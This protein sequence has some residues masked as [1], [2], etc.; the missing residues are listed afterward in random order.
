MEKNRSF[1]NQFVI[2]RLQNIIQMNY[3]KNIKSIFAQSAIAIVFSV[4]FFAMPNDG[5]ATHVVGGELKYRHLSGDQYEI[6]LTFRRDCILGAADAQFD[7]PAT[8]W[9]FDGNGNPQIGLGLNGRLRMNFNNSD[10]LNTFIDSEC[11]FEGTQ[12]CVHETIYRETVRLPENNNGYILAYQRCCRNASINNVIDPLNTGGTWTVEITPEAA[13]VRNNS[14]DFVDWAPVFVCA[15]E[16]VD[17]DHSAIDSDG[18]SLVYRLCTPFLGGD[19]NNPIPT[20]APRPPYNPVIFSDPFSL[21]NLLGGIPLQID[22]QTGRLT[23]T[24]NQVGQFLVGICVDEYRDGIKIGEVRRDFQYNVRICSPPPTAIFE[25]N[26]GNC[27]GPDVAFDN[28]SISA[29]AF[30]WNFDFP[31]TDAAFMST[32][33]NPQFV[34][35]EPGV[36]DVQL[37][38]TRGSDTCSD[39]IVQQVAAI[40]S[41]I[42]VDYDLEILACDGDEGFTIRLI[43][44]SIEPEEGFD[45]TNAD[46]TITQGSESFDFNGSII[47]LDI[48]DEDF[49]VELQVSS[50]TGCRL[51]RMDTISISDFEHVADFDFTLSGCADGDMA[52]LNFF[53]ISDPLNPFDTPIGWAWT[54][55][56]NGQTTMFDTETFSYEVGDSEIITVELIVDFGG[57]CEA[58]VEKEINLQDV[59][60]LGT[61]D[62]DAVG[63]QD[64]TTVDVVFTNTSVDSNPDIEVIGV[65][66]TVTVDGQTF[67]STEDVFAITI[68]KNVEVNLEYTVAF[69]NGCVDIIQES[70]IPGPFATIEFDAEPFVVCLGDSISFVSNPNSDFTY[71]WSPMDGLFFEDPDDR[72]NPLLIGIENTM[73]NVTVSD[74]LCEVESS[75]EIIVLDSRNLMI[76]GDS[77]TCDGSVFLTASGGIGE[78]EFEW[79]T[80]TDF[81]EIIHVGNTLDTEFASNAFTYYVR[82]T[83]ESCN[84]PFAEF[85]VMRSDVFDVVFNGDPVR[86]CLGD[87]VPLLANPNP[88]LTYDWSPLDGIVFI[89]PDNSS[90]AHVIGTTDTEYNVTLSDDFCSIDTSISVVIADDQNFQIIGDSIVCDENVQLVGFGATGI[91]TYEWALDPDF[92]DIFFVG[93]TLDTTLDGLS[94]TYW[95]RFTDNT[96]GELVLSYNVRQFVFDLLY[97]EVFEVCQGDTLQYDVFNQGEGPLTYE[98]QGVNVIDQG[99]TSSPIIGIGADQEDLFEIVFTATNPTGCTFV[100]TVLFEI[101][102]NPVVDFDFELEQGCGTFT[103]CFNTI[104]D[105]NGFPAWD[106]GDPTTTDDISPFSEVC[107]TYPGPG[108]YEV[109]LENLSPLCPFETV[110]KTVTINDMISTDPIDDRIVC[111]GDE[112]TLTAT[113]SDFNIEFVWCDINGDTL[114]VGDIFTTTVNEPFDVIV[115]GSDPNG[116]FD[117]DTINVSPFVF[118]VDVDFPMVFC[119]S[120]D[121]D[122][123]IFINGTQDGFSY[124]WGP[125]ECVVSGGNTAN[126][127]L[128]A[129]A[130][131]EFVLNVVFD[132]LGCQIDTSFSV[133]TFSFGV[134]L[135]AIDEN[136]INTDTINQGEEATIF[137]IEGAEG[138]EFEWSTGETNDTGEIIVSPDETT[139]YSVTITDEMG[140]TTTASL[141]LFVRLPV[142]D[143][144][145]VFLPTAFSPNGDNVNDVL[146]LRSN[147]IDDMEL[148]IYNR[149][150]E[151]V[152][153]TNDQSRGWDGSFNGKTLPPDV[154]AYTLRVVCIN[155]V[156][157]EVRGNVSL[158]K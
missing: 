140:C 64:D 113:T 21:E 115:K 4:L 130:A 50:G 141:T 87:T 96:C 82:F 15:N 124:Q 110:V 75:L 138:F 157:F 91:G 109:T 151:E 74:G 122:I 137:I 9:I 6:T 106:F 142:C 42:D 24:P 81:M 54:I 53:D 136:G 13:D 71:T 85:T 72:S 146:F 61:F 1:R 132:S 144:T 126:P 158:I 66:W 143:E 41:D 149:W 29:T 47:N 118:D 7:N 102:E 65:S 121:M 119:E 18:D 23:G 25:A 107:Y 139:T 147:F 148:L 154:F 97:A 127:I 58:T 125:D 84:D 101:I 30:Q 26:E 63:C 35:D 19:A 90:S 60:P 57:E 80:T 46:W 14:P 34:Y 98:W 78:G 117:M 20:I 31:S 114:V 38:V 108:V 45:I 77:I 95:V 44:R 133:S 134:G 36:Y 5:N 100:D 22:S 33:A 145:D 131:K 86:V 39:T 105:F 70:F 8:V 68:P 92:T 10:T 49:V 76:E 99:D 89:D 59:V 135:D 67:D 156:E 37:I 94:E 103:A 48:L 27:E 73:Y 123:E 2:P 104:G 129:G 52:I 111:L 62:F 55:T 11:G 83:G 155:Q 128:N 28:Q 93:D 153:F 150:G 152:F 51:S 17:F 120:E 40:F 116:C 12:V 43:D 112:V 3:L 56:E 69:A 88:L 32:E 16:D 79:S